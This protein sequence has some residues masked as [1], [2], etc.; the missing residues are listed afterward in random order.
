[1]VVVLL[2]TL[3]TTRIVLHGL[4]VVDYGVYNVVCGFVVMF[5]FLNTSMSNGIQRFM[6]YE[7]SKNGIQSANRVFCN[8]IFIQASLAFIVVVIVEPIGIWYLNNKM[9]IPEDR[10][11]AAGWIFQFAVLNFVVGIMK[12]PFSAAVTAHERMDFYAIMSILKAVL[13][14]A[15]AF[16]IINIQ[17]DKLIIYGLLMSCVFIT[18]LLIFV[19]YCKMNFEECHLRKAFDVNLF[20]KMLGFSGWNLFGSL[21]G[22]A[23]NHGINLILNFF[24]GP[25]VNAARGIATQVNG[26]ISAFV[27]NITMPVRPQVIHSFA[28]GNLKRTMN[29]TYTISKMSCFFL[30]MLAIPI[31]LEIDYVLKI[32]LGDNVPDYASIFT[33]LV[34]MDAIVHNLSSA[35][36]TVVHASGIMRNYQLWGSSFKLLAIPITIIILKI[37]ERPELALL[38]VLLCDVFSHTACLFVMKRIV[39]L[40]LREYFSKVIIPILI[41]LIISLCLITP[42]HCFLS[43]GFERLVIVAICS[44]VIVF[45]VCVLCGFNRQEKEVGLQLT[46]SML[47]KLKQNI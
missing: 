29:L 32:W 23:E 10:L 15:I 9:V 40:S 31:S 4:G 26:G 2:I 37:Y 45:G 30:F 41:V 22:V 6:N 5:G 47:Y 43:E 21:A 44:I 39:S 7:L 16:I 27:S 36:S 8:A 28:V 12:A 34:L 33:I 1:M 20:K 19:C 11:Y 24:F 42:L 35:A 17:T 46:K 13:D 3:F 18:D 25:V 38:I 14:L